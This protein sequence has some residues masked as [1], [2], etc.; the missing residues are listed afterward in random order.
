[1]K[2]KPAKKNPT[3]ATRRNVQ[4]AN[5][6]LDKL[7]DDLANRA[8]EHSEDINWIHERISALV[9]RVVKLENKPTRARR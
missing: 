7:E 5:K 8:K 6:R 9:D 1:M 4:A 2:K 3:D